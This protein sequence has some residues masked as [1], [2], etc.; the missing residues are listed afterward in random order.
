MI[1][2]MYKMPILFSWTGSGIANYLYT[3]NIFDSSNQ[4][5]QIFLS[6]FHDQSLKEKQQEQDP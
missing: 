1:N 6:H 3:H 4:T 2:T 5:H